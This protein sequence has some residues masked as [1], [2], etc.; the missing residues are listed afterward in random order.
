[1][2]LIRS[3][4]V[5]WRFAVALATVV[6]LPAAA[7]AQLSSDDL[8][9]GYALLRSPALGLPP[10]VYG[11]RDVAR[12]NLTARYGQTTD[13]VGTDL[14]S[15]S[16]TVDGAVSRTARLALTAAHLQ[17]SCDDCDPYLSFGLDGE[18]Y[19]AMDTSGTRSAWALLV[20]PWVGYSD[21][22]T[23]KTRVIAA[24]ASIPLLLTFGDR[25]Q[26][27]PYVVPSFGYAQLIVG[28]QAA[29]GTRLAI[30]GG[31][32]VRSAARRLG[33]LLGVQ[34][35]VSDGVEPIVG[36]GVTWSWP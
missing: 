30:G 16:L 33:V 11:V 35:L 1:M 19:I 2:L 26:V 23:D 6:L 36:G 24:G 4:T 3:T 28:G 15:L 25:W 34:R 14:R 12:Y 22:G 10:Q 32:R 27:Q 13:P 7:T 5:L 18:T 21:G 17:P 9:V 29:D 8:L 20:K 31:I